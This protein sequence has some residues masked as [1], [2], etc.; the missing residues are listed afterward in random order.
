MRKAARRQKKKM[1]QGTIL[2]LIA[3]LVFAWAVKINRDNQESKEKSKMV[4][5]ALVLAIV[6]VVVIP[7]FTIAFYKA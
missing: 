3:P 2:L 1:L 4:I 6:G 5:P 7:V